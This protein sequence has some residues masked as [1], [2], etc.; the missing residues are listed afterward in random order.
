MASILHQI[1]SAF[2]SSRNSNINEFESSFS[3]HHTNQCII[4]LP[5]H[6]SNLM[7][8]VDHPELGRWLCCDSIGHTKIGCQS[9]SVRHHPIAS[10]KNKII[11]LNFVRD[12]FYFPLSLFLN[13]LPCSTNPAN[14][15]PQTHSY[16]EKVERILYYLRYHIILRLLYN[17]FIWPLSLI[18]GLV[19]VI[20]WSLFHLILWCF[21]MCILGKKGEVNKYAC[22]GQLKGSPGCQLGPHP[23]PLHVMLPRPPND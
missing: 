2:N 19:S 11:L 20:L 10:E 17:F 5:S 18:V 21:M 1:I 3:R 6:D 7:S 15:L 12:C 14:Y 8:Y 16:F 13:I 22:C 9:G 23:R 4:L